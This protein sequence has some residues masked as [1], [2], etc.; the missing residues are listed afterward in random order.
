MFGSDYCTRIWQVWNGNYH[1]AGRHKLHTVL[2][3][4][5][6]GCAKYSLS[7]FTVRQGHA[8][9]CLITRHSPTKPFFVASFANAIEYIELSRAPLRKTSTLRSLAS[10]ASKLLQISCMKHPFIARSRP[11]PPRVGFIGAAA[12]PALSTTERR[13]VESVRSHRYATRVLERRAWKGEDTSALI[14]KSRASDEKNP[15]R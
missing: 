8:A 6:G 7:V 9:I 10:F 1:Q 4:L 12:Y 13:L 5:R 2:L 11:T 14:D 3:L 15:S